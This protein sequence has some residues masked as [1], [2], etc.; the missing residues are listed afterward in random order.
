[1]NVSADIGWIL[2]ASG[3]FIAFFVVGFTPLAAVWAVLGS[4]A[5]RSEDLQSNTGPII[6]IILIAL[7]AGLFATGTALT[8]AS[9]IPVVSSVAMPVRLL[10]GDVALW[11][12]LVSLGL[13]VVA[14]YLLLRLGE[15]IYQRAVMHGGT[16]LTWRKAMKLEA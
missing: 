16:A 3:W 12:P 2:G 15:R 4:L 7:F 13:T 5:S 14:A 6:G 10:S 9:Y 11:E 1:M 8:V